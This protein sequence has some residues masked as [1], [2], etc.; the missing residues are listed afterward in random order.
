VIVLVWYEMTVAVPAAWIDA[1]LVAS[2]NHELKP[3]RKGLVSPHVSDVAGPGCQE[4]D[5]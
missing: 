1:L 3:N 5:I 4:I 2:K